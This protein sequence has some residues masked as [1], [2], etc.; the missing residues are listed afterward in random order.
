MSTK[1]TIKQGEKVSESGIYE[2]TRSGRRIS[3]RKGQYAAKTPALGEEWE[4]VTDTN[5]LRKSPAPSIARI[6]D[7][8]ITK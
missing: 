5:R 2:A 8:A 6:V 3:M 4:K 7:Q 1:L